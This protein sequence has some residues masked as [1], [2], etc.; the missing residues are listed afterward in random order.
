MFYSSTALKCV[1][2]NF[3][4]LITRTAPADKRTFNRQE[5]RKKIVQRFWLVKTP[6]GF[7]K[8]REFRH[9]FS[10][11]LVVFDGFHGSWTKKTLDS[12]QITPRR[13]VF[14]KSVKIIAILKHATNLANTVQILGPIHTTF[15]IKTPYRICP[16][17]N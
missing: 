12:L 17:C 14:E 7:A 6:I 1:D 15:L 5:S 10:T 11:T 4:S 3:Y 2:F 13:D 16:V 8:S 9:L